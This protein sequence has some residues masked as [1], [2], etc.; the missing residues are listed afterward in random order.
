MTTLN[1][2]DGMIEMPKLELHQRA[3]F[4]GGDHSVV[5]IDEIEV[6]AVFTVDDHGVMGK[7]LSIYYN[8]TRVSDNETLLSIAQR[9]LHP[10][11]ER[12]V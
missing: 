3:I 11:S 10:I 7:T 8:C 9:Y 6:R 4:V 5:T 1:L 2:H 12:E